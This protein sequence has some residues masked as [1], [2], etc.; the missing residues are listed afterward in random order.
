MGSRRSLSLFD[1]PSIPESAA[2]RRTQP[3]YRTLQRAP[4]PAEPTVV[5]INLPAANALKLWNNLEPLEEG[6]DQLPPALEDTATSER[7]VTWVRVTWP[8]GAQSKIAW[9]GINTVFV[10]QRA[11]VANEILPSGNGRPDQVVALAR[12][13]VLSG[14]VRI[15]VTPP[16][17]KPAS[18]RKLTTS[19]LPGRKCQSK[20]RL[21]LAFEPIRNGPR[22]FRPRRR[23][24]DR[25]LRRRLS[26]HAAPGWRDDPRRA[27]ITAR[28]AEGNVAE[29]FIKTCIRAAGG[30]QSHN[31]VRTWCGADVPRQPQKG[32]SKL[33]LVSAP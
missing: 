8:K 22:R 5:E 3:A 19:P 20:T 24:R 14:S 6:A 31:P 32:R 4:V 33:L 10:Q 25:S 9:A 26:G 27:T 11:H 18:G 16:T 15:T 23:S 17:A 29:G 21:P 13:P 2:C 1:I 28:A 12:K 7:V 30:N